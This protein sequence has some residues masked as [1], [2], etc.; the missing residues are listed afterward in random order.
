V[1]ARSSPRRYE[2][3]P[4]ADEEFFAAL[5]FYRESESSKVA[6]DFE[7]ELRRCLT[8]LLRTPEMAPRLGRKNARGKLLRRFPYTLIY[9]VEPDLIYILA[10]AHQNRRPAYWSD[11]L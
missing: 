9:A 11:R 6:S 8:L 3:H 7:S 1:P 4:A 5:R 10:V 2:F